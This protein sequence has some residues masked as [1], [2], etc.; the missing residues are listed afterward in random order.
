MSH[1]SNPGLTGERATLPCKSNHLITWPL[2][3]GWRVGLF[4]IPILAGSAWIASQEIRVARVTYQV[5]TLSIPDLEKALQQD[6]GN[7]DLLHRLGWIYSY[8]PENIN[9]PE[10]M[11]YLRQAAEA[12]PG[13]WDLWS[14]LGLTCDFA[15]DTACSDEAFERARVL[16]PMT[17]TLQWAEGNHYLLTNHQ[18]KAFPCFRRLLELDPHYLDATVKLCLR[19]TQDPQAIFAGVVPQGKD[20]SARFGYL[21]ILASNG[22]YESAM[23]IWGQMI[24][25]LD[26]SPK[27]SSV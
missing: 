4:L 9:L 14:D 16:N 8:S 25:G 18:E 12:S 26:R 17:P 6:P 21:M 3:S 27:L 7:P 13:R 10:A 1:L 15:G 5:D 2:R 22:D 23:R 11:K 24:S 19:A 20:P